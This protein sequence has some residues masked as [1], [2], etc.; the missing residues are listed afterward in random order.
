MAKKKKAQVDQ[1]VEDVVETLEEV[2]DEV[3]EVVEE[4]EETEE[5]VLR[6]D[7]CIDEK[8]GDEVHEELVAFAGYSELC[9]EF[10]YQLMARGCS[11]ETA[12]Q[13]WRKVEETLKDDATL[14]D[15]VSRSI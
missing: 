3:V 7:F 10:M 5:F 8:Y 11:P 6:D 15:L 1:V 12:K 4:E 2:V 9:W 14:G 13:K